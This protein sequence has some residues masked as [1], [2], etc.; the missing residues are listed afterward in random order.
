MWDW[1]RG[2]KAEDRI[3]DEVSENAIDGVGFDKED[4]PQQILEAILRV[5]K[6]VNQF[7]F[8][9]GKGCIYYHVPRGTVWW[10]FNDVKT[11]SKLEKVE[12]DIEESCKNWVNEPE[13]CGGDTKVLYSR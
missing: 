6:K 1:L 9:T 2:K 11:D 3:R 5:H 7:R 10:I 13:M 8:T 4:S 12:L